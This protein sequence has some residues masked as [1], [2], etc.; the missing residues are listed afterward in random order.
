MRRG[1]NDDLQRV[2]DALRDPA[3]LCNRLGLDAKRTGSGFSVLC[4]WHEETNPSCNLRIGGRD[5][6]IR[7]KCFACGNGG[8]AIDLVRQCM[9]LEF[10]DA[11]GIAAEW[12]GV[13]VNAPRAAS[14]RRATPPIDRPVDA[15]T[16]GKA[17]QGVSRQRVLDLHDALLNDEPLLEAVLSSRALTLPVI[18]AALLGYDHDRKA[19]VIPYMLER[20]P[21]YLKFK[22]PRGS[23]P[24]YLREPKGQV[25]FPFGVDSLSGDARVVV[26]EGELDALVLRGLGVENVV[27]APNG[28]QSASGHDTAKHAWLDHLERFADIVICFD[29]DDAGRTG[30]GQLAQRL[31]IDRCRLVKLPDGVTT[32]AGEPAKDPT[33][34]VLAGAQEQL[35]RAIEDARPIEHPLVDHVGGAPMDEYAALLGFGPEGSTRQLNVPTGIACF[36]SVVG[37]IRRAEVTMIYG[38]PGAGKSLLADELLLRLLDR[39]ERCLVVSLE[40]TRAQWLARMGLRVT[41]STAPTQ[42]LDGLRPT[43]TRE[44]YQRLR[45]ALDRRGLFFMRAAGDTPIT[46]VLECLEFARRRYD[47]EFAVIDHLQRLKPP[48]EIDKDWRFNDEMNGMLE[49]FAHR[50]GVGLIIPSHVTLDRRGDKNPRP[51]LLD[52]R[53]GAGAPQN[54][55]CIIGLWRSDIG[56]VQEGE[57]VSAFAALKLR[58]GI[59]RENTWTT[60]GFDVARQGYFDVNT[61]QRADPLLRDA[62]GEGD[63]PPPPPAEDDDVPEGF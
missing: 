55:A 12:A 63:A 38:S 56:R 52:A 42:S 37:G 35:L 3:L 4:P 24:A 26:T 36:D 59:G 6:H 32:A 47:I 49:S 10:A 2:L 28:A 50:S 22:M 9:N 57:A 19:L 20:E 14:E 21:R 53:G 60:I 16:P 33:D 11:L 17:R 30:A 15:F 25:D 5:G 27:S 43:M 58:D 44:Q 41:G 48:P 13:Q 31:G 54:A 62:V 8:D 7:V 51:T 61:T 39:G 40:M 23:K 29:A 46:D 45:E 34:Y 18:E 1:R